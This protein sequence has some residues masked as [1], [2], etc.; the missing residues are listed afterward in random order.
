MHGGNELASAHSSHEADCISLARRYSSALLLLAIAGLLVA[1]GGG[2]G[3]GSAPASSTGPNTATLSWDAWDAVTAPNFAGYRIYFGT[4]RGTYPELQT[5]GKEVTTYTVQ[6]LNSG[7]RY[8]FVVTAYDD[9]SN[10]ESIFSNE[11]IK[12]IP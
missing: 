4:T 9:S 10:S 7:S 1:C 6:G 2:G 3:G 12:D 8:Y 5:V 11:A